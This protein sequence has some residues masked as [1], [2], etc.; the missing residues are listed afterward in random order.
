VT[1]ST[2]SD[3]WGGAPDPRDPDAAS[4]P[5]GIRFLV[6]VLVVLVLPLLLI[7]AAMPGSGGCGGG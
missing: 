1:D 6:L 2:P 3:P 7:A 5:S 4:G